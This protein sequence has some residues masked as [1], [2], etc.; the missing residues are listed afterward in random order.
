MNRK[1][2]KTVVA[3]GVFLTAF[4][5][6]AFVWPPSG[7]SATVPAGEEVTV[8]AWSELNQVRNVTVEAGAK[9]ILNTPTAPSNVF[10][11]GAGTVVKRSADD[12]ALGTRQVDFLGDF[13]LENGTSACNVTGALGNMMAGCGG[14]CVQAGATLVVP[15]GVKFGLR[16]LHLA[17]KVIVSSTTQGVFPLVSVES[18]TAEIESNANGYLISMCFNEDYVPWV[19]WAYVN[20]NGHK[21]RWSGTAKSQ[22]SSVSVTNGG[23]IVYSPGANPSYPRE[24]LL[25]EN[26]SL[27]EADAG[28]LTAEG[29]MTLSSWNETLPQ[30]RPLTLKSGLTTRAVSYN[31][32]T[33]DYGFRTNVNDWAG[34]VT[35]DGAAVGLAATGTGNCRQAN[36][37]GKVTGTGY[38][39]S[40][41]A[42]QS[43]FGR[44]ALLSPE[45][46]YTGGTRVY[47]KNF[48]CGIF[49]YWPESI[50]DN[51]GV[52]VDGGY[53][54]AV[55]GPDEAPRWTKSGFFALANAATWQ[56]AWSFPAVA[57]HE[58]SP[59]GVVFTA[60][61]ID[62]GETNPAA[63]GLAVAS[64][65]VT[66]T[67]VS[68]S[69]EHHLGAFG[70]TL[71]VTGAGTK[72][73]LGA[74]W[75]TGVNATT[76]GML[77]VSDGAELVTSTN[78]ILV[79][80][81]AETA[82]N[83][84]A[85]RAH[86]LVS[87]ATVRT[88]YSP[89]AYP[90]FF[91]GALLLGSYGRATM[92]ICGDRTLVTNKIV[93]GG[94]YGAKN[95]K[96]KGA[97]AVYQRGGKVVQVTNDTG[98]DLAAN[99][100]QNG[101]GYWETSGGETEFYGTQSVGA[102]GIGELRVLSGGRAKWTPTPYTWANQANVN[103]GNPSGRGHVYIRGGQASGAVYTYFSGEWN[104]LTVEGEGSTYVSDY[105][106]HSALAGYDLPTFVN[107]AD[108]G[109]LETRGMTLGSARTAYAPY[110][111]RTFTAG[112]NG[113]T[114]RLRSAANPFGYRGEDFAIS[115][116]RIYEKGLTI[117]TNGQNCEIPTALA[118][119]TG[120]GVKKIDFQTVSAAVSTNDH[121]VPPFVT[122]S[123]G[124]GWGAAAAS[125]FESSTETVTGIH[126]ISPGCY[127]SA[128]TARLYAERNDNASDLVLTDIACEMAPNVAGPFTKAGEG[129][130]TLSGTNSWGQSTTVAGGTLKAASDKAIPNGTVLNLSGGTLDLN[131]HD[132]SF[133][134]VTGTGG[135]VVNGNV[136]LTGTWT[137]DAADILA[138]KTV[139]LEGT[140]DLTA[141]TVT[142]THPELLTTPEARASKKLTIV[143]AT[144]II[145]P[146]KFAPT[147]PDGWKSRATATNL[148]IWPT[149][150]LLVIVR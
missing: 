117:D 80:Q 24:F 104:M 61:E 64:G 29:P 23:E 142:I 26:V 134:G 74:T 115:S 130:L 127:E 71:A 143:T 138:G 92:E 9:V 6:L 43:E 4:P 129:V 11:L 12:W 144:N 36:V 102:Y 141:V 119:A 140:L 50:P 58:V 109:V 87:N 107:V 5:C 114:V 145:A 54:A 82:W 103:I 53:V 95:Q 10:F 84:R 8:N 77:E 56:N 128:P 65:R 135:S 78:C 106:Y 101:M 124:N 15:Q 136:R 85:P 70:G 146:E 105:L 59:T 47:G 62:A 79:G 46:D 13:V 88:D 72:V 42:N 86:V 45:N 48:G 39:Q 25:R 132:V 30:N 33:G 17:G 83:Y 69:R 123:G 91:R 38:L 52:A 147:L 44:L 32:G 19:N 2:L 126:V 66:L 37:S 121:C 68:D 137:I 40:G 31:I 76:P 149:V 55:W 51:A 67:G 89:E 116:V 122:F 34:T 150:G 1:S 112:F 73:Q 96:K 18:D 22:W 98:V 100:G 81:V 94:S 118:G 131:G 21:L 27:G 99:I 113:G 7:N 90:D 97:G 28:P 148:Q 108:G 14:L 75:V 111:D 63:S 133:A 35:L 93:V 120:L 125:D 60:A 49:A 110:L 139:V 20:M 3:S 41:L 57:A 16:E